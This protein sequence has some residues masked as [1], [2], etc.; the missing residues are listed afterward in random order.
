M[1]VMTTYVNASH[2]YILELR[3]RVTLPLLLSKWGPRSL[4][5]GGVQRGR[6]SG[7]CSRSFE[8]PRALQGEGWG[9]G[10]GLGELSHS[11]LGL[12]RRAAVLQC[13]TRGQQITSLHAPA[14]HTSGLTLA[15]PPSPQYCP[16][17]ISQMRGLRLN[18]GGRLQNYEP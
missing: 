10:D 6:S 8:I 14:R 5:N 7:W 1:Y 17:P 3:K 11:F 18:E 9:L 15:P 12:A 2:G 16:H 13:T 4:R